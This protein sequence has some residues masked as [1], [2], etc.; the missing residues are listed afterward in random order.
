MPLSLSAVAIADIDRPAAIS[1]SKCTG[2][3]A[4]RCLS[5]LQICFYRPHL[6][7]VIA[8]GTIPKLPGP[9]MTV[10]A[11]RLRATANAW[12]RRSAVCDLISAILDVAACH[13]RRVESCPSRSLSEVTLL[14]HS[15]CSPSEREARHEAT[16]FHNFSRRR[17]GGVAARCARAAEGGAGDRRPQHRVAQPVC[18]TVYGRVPP[19]TE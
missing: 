11:D 2:G 13:V 15:S 19:G 12:C 7:Q 9:P 3:Q 10:I 6:S 18:C 5:K 4:F 8:P 1:G 14:S 16:R 17:D